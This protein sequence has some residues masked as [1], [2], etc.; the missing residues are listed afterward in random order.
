MA[1]TVA[2]K[3]AMAARTTNALPFILPPPMQN[4]AGAVGVSQGHPS[5]S[6]GPR[7]STKRSLP[8]GSRKSNN[9]RTFS[10]LPRVADVSED[11]LDFRQDRRIVDRRRHLVL[12]RI[13]DLL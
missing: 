9:S 3:S 8:Q 12:F 2:A 1:G 7:L 6:Q 5:P 11:I 4:Y 13:G 10:R